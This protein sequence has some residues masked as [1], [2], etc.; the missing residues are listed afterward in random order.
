[1]TA[2][3]VIEQIRAL[4]TLD[5]LEKVVKASEEHLAELLGD[6][7]A[8]KCDEELREGKVKPMTHEE[9]FGSVRN[10]IREA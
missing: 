2:D 6:L 10:R 3:Q 8:V 5:E 9:V 1:M 7:D 4:S